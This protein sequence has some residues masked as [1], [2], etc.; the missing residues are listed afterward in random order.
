MDCWTDLSNSVSDLQTSIT[1]YLDHRNTHPKPYRWTA[2][3][4]DILTKVNR[5]NS[6]LKT[7]H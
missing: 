6:L 2:K 7:E 4:S 3:A 1:V 5:A